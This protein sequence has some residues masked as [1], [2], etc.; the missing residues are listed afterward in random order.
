MSASKELASGP[1]DA[2]AEALAEMEDNDDLEFTITPIIDL[3]N[4][5]S[6]DIAQLLRTPVQLGQ[7][8]AKL[9]AEVD[10]NGN[11]PVAETTQI[12]NKFDCTGMVVREEADIDRIAAKL[13]QKQQTASRGRG[14]RAP[15]R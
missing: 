8:S 11:R 4:V 7:T 6:T 13:Y 15:A 2:V 14:V 10:Q 3:S 1:I 12:V 9:A 5:R